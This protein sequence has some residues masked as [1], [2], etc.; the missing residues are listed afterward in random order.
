MAYTPIWRQPANFFVRP[1]SRGLS[2]SN[3]CRVPSAVASAKIGNF[4]AADSGASLMNV[5]ADFGTNL[6]QCM[7]PQQRWIYISLQTT[8]EC[9]CLCNTQAH[10]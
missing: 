4:T 6:E 8:A 10:G 1:R 5:V 7:G 2:G 3:S 9:I